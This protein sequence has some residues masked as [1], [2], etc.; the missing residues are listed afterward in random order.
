MKSLGAS[1]VL[2]LCLLISWQIAPHSLLVPKHLLMGAWE[3]AEGPGEQ[4]IQLW[5]KR[6]T[7]GLL[8]CWL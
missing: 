8:R 1:D 6:P 4:V 7:R 5:G 2:S 3:A